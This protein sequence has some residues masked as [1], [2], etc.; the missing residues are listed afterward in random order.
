ML[1][2]HSPRLFSLACCSSKFIK[3]KTMP[4]LKKWSGLFSILVTEILNLRDCSQ[5]HC[6]QSQQQA[7]GAPRPVVADAEK[8]NGLIR[9]GEA[10]CKLLG[11][12]ARRRKAGKPFAPNRHAACI[13]LLATTSGRRLLRLPRMGGISTPL[14]RPW[15]APFVPGV[16]PEERGIRPPCF[17]AAYAWLNGNGAAWADSPVPPYSVLNALCAASPLVEVF[18]GGGTGEGAFFKGCVIENG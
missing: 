14:G 2:W 17:P 4:N 16:T 13:L 11:R 3:A 15:L 10:F 12:N 7:A 8:S 1:F 5:L 18:A 6:F 9:H